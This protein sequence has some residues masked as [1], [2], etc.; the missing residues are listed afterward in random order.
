MNENDKIKLKEPLSYIDQVKRLKDEHRII[1]NDEKNALRILKQV[2]Y[3]K[4]MGYAL[5]FVDPNDKE[6]YIDCSIEK[7]YDLYIFDSKF[8]NMLLRFIGYIE[9]EFKTKIANYLSNTY[10]S[11]CLMEKCFFNDYKIEG[12]I[13][14]Y[15]SLI[16]GF[17]KEVERRNDNPIIQHHIEKYSGHF[18]LWVSIEFFTF[19]DAITLFRLMFE[20]DKKECF[21]KIKDKLYGWLLNLREIRNKCAHN[22]RLYNVVLKQQVSLFRNDKYN[23]DSIDKRKMLA[24]LIAVKRMLNNDDRW[25]ELLEELR[26]LIDEYKDDVSYESL[27]FTNDWIKILNS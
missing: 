25:K 1:I 21:G 12:D 11:E 27:G 13:S 4:L 16:D 10:G 20:N 26:Q 18:P 14:A 19:G 8:K 23:I 3:Y 22:N 24:S 7:L 5:E 9:V 2:N 6:K 15:E 17:N